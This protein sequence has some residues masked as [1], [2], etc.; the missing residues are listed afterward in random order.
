MNMDRNSV[1]GF[2]LLAVL[3]FVYLFVS[4]KES[5][6]LQMQQRREQDSL[7]RVQRLRDSITLSKD[8]ARAVAQSAKDT[9]STGFRLKSSVELTTMENDLIK[10]YFTSKG[11]QP[12]KV[13]LKKYASFRDSTVILGGSDFDK[14]GY[15]V[16]VDGNNALPVSDLYFSGSGIQKMQDLSLIHI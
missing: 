2:I 10:V 6:Q 8:T 7:A 11:G 1:I 3:L 4:T 9:S 14:F 15:M 5:Q 16:R 12:L 13:E